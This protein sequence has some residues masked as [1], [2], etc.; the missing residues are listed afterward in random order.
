VMDQ[1]SGPARAD[2]DLDEGKLIELVLDGS[3]ASYDLLV[4]QYQEVVFRVAWLLLRDSDAAE[5]AAQS[6]FIKAYHAL[7]RFDRKRPFKPWLLQIVS[8]EARN[9]R[10][11]AA[12]RTTLVESAGYNQDWDAAV[13]SPESH[14][15]RGEQSERLLEA[16]SKLDDRDQNVL[17]LRYYMQLSEAEMSDAMA[18]RKGTVKS[19][20]SRAQKRLKELIDSDYPDLAS[21]MVNTAASEL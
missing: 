20:L 2:I 6:A 10:R 1:D 14:A 11:S 8:N 3:G 12:R 7:N 16:I 21:S 17:H 15:V 4:M 9:M 13:E 5:D 18:V 19:R